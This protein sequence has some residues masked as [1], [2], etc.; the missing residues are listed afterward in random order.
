MNGYAAHQLN[1]VTSLLG[2]TPLLSRP[3]TN[4]LEVH[5]LLREGLPGT[6]LDHLVQSLVVLR[7]ADYLEKAF[8]MSLRTYQRRLDKPS[9]P[10]SQEQSGRAWQF[11]ELL[12]RATDMLG[13][14]EE[15]ERWLEKP[16][17][18]LEGRRPIDLLSTPA[19]VE[20]VDDYLTRI[21]Y[22]VYA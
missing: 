4:A 2:G 6:A 3:L 5:E 11:A 18:A 13:S 14:Q 19:G 16:A 1:K 15:A 21:E 9:Q 17:I 22:G 12:T 20:L 10:L 8:G 7:K